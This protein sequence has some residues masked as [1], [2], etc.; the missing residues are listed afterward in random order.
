MLHLG[1]CNPG[2]VCGLEEEITENFPTEKNLGVLGDEMFDGSQLCVLAAQKSSASWT[3]S[4]EAW[5]AE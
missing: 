1:Q 3:A 5:P 2:N 4:K